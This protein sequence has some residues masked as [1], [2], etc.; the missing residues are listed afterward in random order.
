VERILGEGGMGVVVLAEHVQLGQRV[1]LKVLLPEMLRQTDIVA[2]FQREARATARLKNDHVARILDV[3]ELESGVPYIVMEYLEGSDLGDLLAEQGPPRPELAVHYVLQAC[4]ALAEAHGCGIIHR[5]LKPTNLFLTRT[6]GGAPLVKV[7][8]FGVSRFNEASTVDVQLTRTASVVGSPLYMAPEQMRAARNADERSDIWALGVILYE[9]LTGVVPFKGESMTDLFAKIVSGPPPAPHVLRPEVS[10]SLSAIVMRCLSVD[11][12][13][14]PANIAELSLELAGFGESAGRAA[15]ERSFS[16]RSAPDPS[17]VGGSVAAVSA[18]T[19]ANSRDVSVPT[20]AA[21]WANRRR[22]LLLASAGC[23][24]F[25]MVLV[26][27]LVLGRNQDD[28]ADD[29]GLDPTFVAATTVRAAPA[30]LPESKATASAPPPAATA[31]PSEASSAVGATP[32]STSSMRA[33]KRSPASVTT[34]APAPK[35]SAGARPAAS[36]P[37]APKDDPFQNRTSF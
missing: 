1:A 4:E 27:L 2:R 15:S 17:V 19:D 32:T 29:V 35:P 18:S 20:A 11:P 28:R 37:S 23:I 8:D 10:P 30:A 16:V 14:R 3:G 31:T 36:P 5:D 22:R 34:K 9:F 6:R 13:G 7:L 33:R 25:G 21:K 24:L 12:A 26:W